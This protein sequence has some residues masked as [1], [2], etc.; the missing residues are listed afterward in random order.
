VKV[1]VPEEAQESEET[2][3]KISS[4]VEKETSEIEEGSGGEEEKKE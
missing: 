4:E 1:L 3:T 2:E